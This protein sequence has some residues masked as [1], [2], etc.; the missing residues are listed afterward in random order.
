M[1]PAPAVLTALALRCARALREHATGPKVPNW[2]R[3]MEIFVL[4]DMQELESAKILLG[5]LLESGQITDPQEM[6]FLQ[7][8]LKQMS[9]RSQAK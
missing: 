7:E 6:R 2:A 5:G 8:R 9:A 4:E 3:Q 1:T